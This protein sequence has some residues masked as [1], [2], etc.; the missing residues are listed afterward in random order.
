MSAKGLALLMAAMTG[1]FALLAGACSDRGFVPLEVG[2]CLP[3]GA[4]VEGE[5][6]QRPTVVNCAERHRYE[7]FAVERLDPPSD[8]WPG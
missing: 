6:A 3:D 5:R 1:G 8:E 7:V 2:Q 4:N